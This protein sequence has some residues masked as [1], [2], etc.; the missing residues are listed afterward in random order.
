[1]FQ[2]FQLGL[3]RNVLNSVG[4]KTNR[5][6]IVIETS[7]GSIKLNIHINISRTADNYCIGRPA[8]GAGIR[9]PYPKFTGVGCRKKSIC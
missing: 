9:Y 8:I 1:M 2:Q 4:Y 3:K 6:I 7:L 5:K